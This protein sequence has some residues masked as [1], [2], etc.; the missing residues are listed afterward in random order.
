MNDPRGGPELVAVAWPI[1]PGR[2]A[3]VPLTALNG[4]EFCPEGHE[5]GAPLVV[6]AGLG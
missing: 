1:A 3:W 2:G 4:I 5:M 6:L